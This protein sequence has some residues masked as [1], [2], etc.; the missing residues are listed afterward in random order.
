[1]ARIVTAYEC[2]VNPDRVISQIEGGTVMA[3]GRARFESVAFNRGRAARPAPRSHPDVTFGPP[4][5]D[6][7]L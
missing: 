3:L 1:V 6:V 4:V 2:V 5:F 7:G